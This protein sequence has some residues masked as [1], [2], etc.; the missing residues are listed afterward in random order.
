MARRRNYTV[1]KRPNFNGVH[2]SSQPPVLGALNQFMPDFSSNNTRA[3][4]QPNERPPF[5]FTPY[6]N[7]THVHDIVK[8]CFVNN[9]NCYD[10]F[11]AFARSGLVTMSDFA[12]AT[13]GCLWSP[14]TSEQ[15][16]RAIDTSMNGQPRGQVQAE[17]IDRFLHFS[18]RKNLN[19]LHDDLMQRVESKISM[20]QR[21]VSIA[22][23]FSYTG[24]PGVPECS[25]AEF[26]NVLVRLGQ[27]LTE[28]DLL[29]LAKKYQAG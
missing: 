13:A 17:D 10:H 18:C 19:L 7:D 14:Q 22:S 8:I 25:Y 12:Q 29:F 16:F 24:R 11:S 21:G 3:G 26:K 1:P 9:K 20:T 15:I 5:S 2:V 23:E 27:D 4:T 6:H 28:T